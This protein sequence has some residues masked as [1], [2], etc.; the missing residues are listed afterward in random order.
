MNWLHK[1]GAVDKQRVRTAQ[2]NIIKYETCGLII[3]VII[4][5]YTNDSATYT[6]CSAY[7][8]LFQRLQCYVTGDI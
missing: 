5:V 8:I 2:L 1:I 4:L 6:Q 3:V 7:T